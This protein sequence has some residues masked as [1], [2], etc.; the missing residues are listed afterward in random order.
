[1]SQVWG[2]LRMFNES[3]SRLFKR[4]IYRLVLWLLMPLFLGVAYFVALVARARRETGKPRLVWGSTPIISNSYWSTAM[5]QAG[6]ESETFTFDYYAV[7]N[8]RDDWDRILSEEYSWA[9]AAV[10]PL[11]AFIGSL[12]RYDVFFISFDGFFIGRTPFAR[13][14]SHILKFAGK[15]TVVM[16]YGSDSYVYRRIRSVAT[17]H[18][19]LM[20]YPLAARDQ[21]RITRT[22]DYWCQNADV[23]IPG[24]M[25]PDGFGRWDV[26]I[27][28]YV[29]VDLNTWAPSNRRNFADGTSGSVAVAHA[30]NHRGFKGTE[31]IIQAVREL[32]KE[33][34]KIQLL[35]LE[36]IQNAEV[37]RILRE[38]T[39]ILVDQ[40]ICTGH[41]LNAVEGL[42]SGL[43]VISNLEDEA[44]VMPWR[45]WSYFAECPIVSASPETL[46]EVLRHLVTRPKLRQQL[47]EAGRAYAEKYHGLDSAQ[48]LFSNVI[49]YVYGRKESLINLYHPLVGEYPN[50]RPKIQHP[51]FNNRIVD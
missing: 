11:I 24:V 41:G 50:R 23:V 15:K 19:L 18:G 46:A 13:F 42:A 9:P 47:G 3:P 25:G 12:L 27:P 37:R 8:R 51:L 48:Y 4:V 14:Q 32:Q 33:G 36:R 31:F 21:Q 10:K 34:L 39:D 17:L 1:M 5:R 2:I 7:I 26:L 28:S 20:S 49:D 45:R 35:L 29:A 6:Y 22:V 40:I 38:E 44:Y 30:P 16:P 43:P